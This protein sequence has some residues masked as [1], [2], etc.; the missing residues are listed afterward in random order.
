M[1]VLIDIIN[2]RTVEPLLLG[3]PESVGLLAFGVGLAT[4]AVI[5]RWFLSRGD[6]ERSKE[7]KREVN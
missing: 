4:A 2:F 6:A 7:G 1:L 5:I 3:I